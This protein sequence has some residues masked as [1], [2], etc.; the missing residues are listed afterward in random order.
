MTL[1]YD[2]YRP[3]PSSVSSWVS[4]SSARA[5]AD[6]KEPLLGISGNFA[7]PGGPVM[8][9]KRCVNLYEHFVFMKAR[10]FESGAIDADRDLAEAVSRTCFVVFENPRLR[11]A[12]GP[13]FADETGRVYVDHR[14]AAHLLELGLSPGANPAFKAFV[15]GMARVA[16]LH[17][18]GRPAPSAIELPAVL[19]TGYAGGWRS[20][21]TVRAKDLV[22]KGGREVAHALGYLE[23]RALAYSAEAGRRLY[24]NL[25]GLGAPSDAAVLSASRSRRP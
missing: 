9:T 4:T 23:P 17:A 20:C 19:K 25:I 22:E 15:T 11:D 13:V 3:A 2:T 5:P 7:R 21:E 24:E 14:V 8:P 10:L 1:A 16:A 18:S 6:P 12:F